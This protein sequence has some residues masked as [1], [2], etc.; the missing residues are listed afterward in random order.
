MT[1]RADDIGERCSALAG[2]TFDQ[3][4]Y[5]ERDVLYL[6]A[7]RAAHDLPAA[8]RQRGV[9]PVSAIRAALPMPCSDSVA[10]AVALRRGVKRT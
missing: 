9:P 5:D 3:H 2:T 4:E 10:R 6:S 8:A 1:E 7:R